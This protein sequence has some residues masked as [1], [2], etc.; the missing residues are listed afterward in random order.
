[1]MQEFIVEARRR[2]VALSM[3][4]LCGAACAQVNVLKNGSFERRSFSGVPDR[5]VQQYTGGRVSVVSG[6]PTPCGDY[7]FEIDDTSATQSSGIASEAIPVIPGQSY[8]AEAYLRSADGSASAG[9]LY[10]K[11]YDAAGLENASASTGVTNSSGDWDYVGVTA[12]APADAVIARVVCYSTVAAVQRHRFDGVSFRRLISEPSMETVYY[13][14]PVAVGSGSGTSKTHAAKYNSSTLWA[15]V[16]ASVNTNSVTLKFL[17]GEYIIDQPA[18]T[19]AVQSVGNE[20]HSLTLEGERPYG[21]VFNRTESATTQT[22]SYVTVK[23]TTNLVV[24]HLHW[25][26]DTAQSG[27]LVNYCM[28][29]GSKT[30]GETKNVYVEGCSFVGL[31]WNTYGAMGYHY[32]TTHGGRVAHCEF[33]RGGYSSGF[34]MIYNAYGSYDLLF[35]DN[36]FQDC[37]GSYLRLRGGCHEGVVRSNE[38]VSTTSAFNHPFV[39]MPTFN[40]INPGDETW[41]RNF[42]ILNNQFTYMT[43]G[44]GNNCAINWYH[45]GF[46]PLRAPGVLWDYLLTTAEKNILLSTNVAAK[47]QLIRRNFGVNFDSQVEM[48][49]NV[50]SGYHA[51]LMRLYTTTAY[52]WTNSSGVVTNCPNYGGNGTYNV[53]DI[54]ASGRAPATA[55]AWIIN[56]SGMWDAPGAWSSSEVPNNIGSFAWITNNITAPRT[57]T[58]DTDVTLAQ[59]EIGAL[60]GLNPFAINSW[61]GS[62]LTFNNDNNGAMLVSASGHI[63]D[64][65][66]APIMLADDLSILN[67]K[68]LTIKGSIGEYGGVSRWGG[69]PRFV[70]KGGAGRLTLE[71][72]HTY[73]GGTFIDAGELAVNGSLRSGVVVGAGGRLS[74]NATVSGIVEVSNGGILSPGSGGIGVM[75][76]TRELVLLAGSTNVIDISAAARTNDSIRGMRVVNYGGTLKIVNLQGTFAKG[77]S[78]RLFSAETYAGGF[79]SMNLPTLNLGLIWEWNPS[80]GTLSVS[81]KMSTT[82]TNLS[83][84]VAAEGMF[85]SWPE[86]HR[87]W[88]LQSNSIGIHLPTAWFDVAGSQGGTSF[89]IPYPQPDP[90]QFYRLRKP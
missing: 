70:V 19:M 37:M 75:T 34:H 81:D 5:W 12:V 50:L 59:L 7:V 23:W 4:L 76:I 53:S 79:T 16:R 87:G 10:I 78:F 21:T 41:G 42:R 67:T 90:M 72:G 3:L 14:A 48:I 54:H 51:E 22:V 84:A 35:E 57:N 8:R 15:A 30:G 24:R 47:K 29:I 33:I 31:S 56:A 66:Y 80:I 43:R 63:A 45:S 1:M 60:N 77:D 52:S 13:A 71:G 69:G 83:F 28:S 85:L 40:D 18:A 55:N 17:S 74:G 27:R 32:S 39:Q 58:I 68:Q 11:Y 26:N 82:P 6:V 61:G 62:T 86:S 88:M 46:D 2:I 65:V 49:G 73:T 20:R 89:F 64:T 44:D 9:R 36:Y 25:E 38:F